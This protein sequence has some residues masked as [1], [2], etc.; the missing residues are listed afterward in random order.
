MAKAA[1]KTKAKE[2][3]KPKNKAVATVAPS[4][5][6]VPAAYANQPT[7]FENDRIDD[8]VIPFFTILQGLSPQMQTVD[9]A[10]LGTI[11][12]TSSNEMFPDG[13]NMVVCRKVYQY[14]EW[15]PN[16]GGFVG[17]HQPDSEVVKK[18]LAAVD[19]DKFSKLKTEAGNDLIESKYIYGVLCDGEKNPMGFAVIGF[20]STKIKK[21]NAWNTDARN[22]LG[23]FG[24]PMHAL[25]WHFGVTKERNAKGE[26]F[27]WTH[28]LLGGNKDAALVDPV[29]DKALFEAVAGLMNRS[30]V[31]IDHGAERGD[32]ADGDAM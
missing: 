29:A 31:K 3:P 2:E 7:G 8:F 6:N 1:T 13:I 14:V 20:S 10:K 30:D 16:R 15:L 4:H 28:T 23:Q 26:F 12:N 18:A 25:A 22:K 24:L 21:Y 17:A 11:I 5:P 9:G 19:G 32:E 27:N